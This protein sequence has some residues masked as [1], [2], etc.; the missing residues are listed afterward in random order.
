MKTA[1]APAAR[2]AVVRRRDCRLCLG[3]NLELVL[4]LA[5]APLVDAYVPKEKAHLPQPSYPLDLFLCNDCGLT[6]LLDV[7]DPELI[8][9]DYIYETVSSLGLVE[10]FDAYAADAIER[11][12][13]KKGSLVVDVGSNDGTLLKSFQKRGMKVLG[14]DPARTIAE[15]ATREGVETLPLFFTRETSKE[16]RRK[17]G[18]A[19]VITTNNIYANVDD[20]H[21]ITEAIRGLLA[22]DGVY[23]LES[24]Y[25][26]DLI[27]NMVFD[28]IYHE[29][30]TYF[31]LKPLDL[32][33]RA[34]GMEIIDV[35]RVP[36]KGGSM[37]YTM[38]RMGGPR[39]VSPAV[40]ELLA[41]EER[42]GLHA[43]A[44]YRAFAA[45]IEDLKKR[46]V[47]RLKGLKAQGKTIAAYGASA[48]STTFVYHFGI[49]ALLDFFVDDYRLKQN[50]FSPGH[51]IPVLP[52]TALH[53]RKPD[54]VL[55]VAW[56]YAEP[57]IKKNAAYLKQGGRFIVPV[58]ELKEL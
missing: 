40:Q 39:K 22:D 15:R 12:A 32:F 55:I 45:K 29:H 53:E 7:V 27:D 21:E 41:R 48:T 26:G 11:R 6:Q 18:P 19:S 16:V 44:T 10:H 2:P 47:G 8:Y 37:R 43:A 30:L 34:K 50:T 36:T 49:G 24:S 52:S 25:V 4:P 35:Q 58:P 31:S 51:H 38:Q 17:Y 33:F 54:Y 46:V 13:L 42:G 56:R 1:S 9:P 28:F 23:V 3:K 14:I 5:P 20:L 57:I